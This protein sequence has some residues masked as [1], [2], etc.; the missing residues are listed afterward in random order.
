M[1]STFRKGSEQSGQAT[2]LADQAAATAMNALLPYAKN[3]ARVG[4]V[5]YGQLGN[6]LKTGQLPPSLS[7]T[8]PLQDIAGQQQTANQQILDTGTR[9]GQLNSALANNVLQ[10]QLA[11]QSMTSQM[12]Q[13]LFN[14]GLGGSSLGFGGMN[15]AISGAQNS[16]GILSTLGAQRIGQNQAFQGG[17][18]Q[19]AGRFLGKGA[20]AM[21]GK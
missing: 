20:G 8:G 21:G 6:F 4:N 2:G 10:G 15:N 17:L 5:G 12:Q 14:A 13:N 11:R 3:A 7:L 19:L 16:A 9:G 18:G 1:G